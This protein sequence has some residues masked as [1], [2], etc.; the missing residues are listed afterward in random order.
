MS[1]SIVDQ[2]Q[3]TDW[4]TPVKVKDG[5]GI[6]QTADVRGNS[7]MKW[8]QSLTDL[9]NRPI[10]NRVTATSTGINVTSTG[11][12]LS[13]GLGT[14]LIQPK[15][16]AELTVKAR[17]SFSL[18]AGN[19]PILVYVYRTS[20]AIPALNAAPGVGD[21]VVGGGPFGGGATFSPDEQAGSLSFLDTGLDV[22]KSYAYYFALKSPNGTVATLLNAS[23]LLVLERA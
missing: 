23:Q 5:A 6:G 2:I 13:T 3:P 1:R 4:Q 9:L 19:G 15:R 14:A 10:N 11:A 18:S 8:L 7:R 21:V 16:Y 17:V 20:G 22:S 12:I